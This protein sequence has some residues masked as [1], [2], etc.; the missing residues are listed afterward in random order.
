M[1]IAGTMHESSSI[2]GDKGG[3]VSNGHMLK[4]NAID[5]PL[6]ALREEDNWGMCYC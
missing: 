4:K 2:I 3:N 6:F 5:N 1:D